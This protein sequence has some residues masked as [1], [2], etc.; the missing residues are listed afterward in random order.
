M[1]RQTAEQ[2]QHDH[3]NHGDASPA[4]QVAQNADAELTAAALHDHPQVAHHEHTMPG[5][6]QHHGDHTGGHV[7]HSEAMF[8]R[9]FWISLVLT[10]PILI[11]AP[12]F[13]QLLHFTAPQF[14]GSAWLSPILAS[15]IYWYCGWV[16]LTGAG[17][18]LRARLPGMMTL[19]ALAISTAYFYSLAITAGLVAG[20][21]FYWEL[22]T[23]VTIMLLGHWMEMRA[24][25]SAQ[26]AL[27]EL[28]KLLPDMAERIVPHATGNGAAETEQVPVSALQ[29]DDLVLVRPGAAIQGLF[30]L[31]QIK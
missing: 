31:R 17:A 14:P 11:D 2:H 1:E 27:N 13:Q 6:M 30:M 19:V 3:H 7:G 12:L 4:E 5:G 28:A 15:V 22:A 16:F 18:E 20:M 26:S 25:N 23:L 10:I 29:V 8:R 21:S 9:P 24:V